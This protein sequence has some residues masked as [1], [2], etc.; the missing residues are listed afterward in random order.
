MEQLVYNQ[1]IG[2]SR[3]KIVWP[4]NLKV[5]DFVLPDWYKPGSS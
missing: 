5:T 1:T 2:E 3:P 4:D